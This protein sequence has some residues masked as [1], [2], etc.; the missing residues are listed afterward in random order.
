MSASRANVSSAF[1]GN[2]RC[3][4]NKFLLRFNNAFGNRF[5]DDWLLY[6]EGNM[7]RKTTVTQTGN[8]NNRQGNGNTY[9]NTAT[10][11]KALDSVVKSQE[12]IDRPLIIIEQMQK[13]LSYFIGG[14]NVSKSE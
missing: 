10:L 8:N 7:L 12:Q 4:T 9:N 6:G 3:L 5:N 11:D 14:N 13:D 1:G 2:D